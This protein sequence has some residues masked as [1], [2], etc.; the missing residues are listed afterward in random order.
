MDLKSLIETVGIVGVWAIVF[1]E[2]SFVFFLPGDS[3][4]FTAGILA[5]RGYFNVYIFALGCFVAAVAGN[6]FGYT[7]GKKFGKR[8]FSKEDSIL[9]H[10]DHLKKANSFYEKYGKKTIVLA[11]FIPVV[12]TFAPIAAGMGDMHYP[13]FFTY[14]IIGGLVWALGLTFAGF[15]LGNT[16]PDIDKYLLPIIILIVIISVAPPLFHI[17]KEPSHRKELMRRLPIFKGFDKK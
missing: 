6:N 12:R 8:V 16:I 2:S 3:L 9:F 4:L 7:F 17:L 13:T 15:W 14:N 1:A 11:R 5:S 10:K